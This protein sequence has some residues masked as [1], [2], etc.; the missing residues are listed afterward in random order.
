MLLEAAK[1]NDVE[2]VK[3]LLK[4]KRIK[5]FIRDRTAKARARLLTKEWKI[6][7]P[8]DKLIGLLYSTHGRPCSCY[9][10]NKFNWQA[11]KLKVLLRE[12][13]SES[14]NDIDKVS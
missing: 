7:N 5:R 11:I 9:I 3:T 12:L 8:S 13:A 4:N 1:N 6:D 14:N 2:L 10:C